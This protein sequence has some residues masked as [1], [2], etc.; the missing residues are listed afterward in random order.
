MLDAST[1]A[2]LSTELQ[3]PTGVGAVIVTTNG[4]SA[5]CMSPRKQVSTPSAM[6]QSALFSV[7]V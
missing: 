6:A 7:Q 4:G 1:V 2:V 5:G 3:M